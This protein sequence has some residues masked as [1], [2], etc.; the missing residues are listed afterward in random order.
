MI[1]E[2]DWNEIRGFFLKNGKE[3]LNEYIGGK[4]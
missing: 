1:I 2:V 4:L 3:L